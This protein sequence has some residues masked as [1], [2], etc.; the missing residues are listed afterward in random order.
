MDHGVAFLLG[1]FG[2]LFVER[3]RGVGE[4]R[5]ALRLL[6]AEIDRNEEIIRT[7]RER[8][9]GRPLEM[10]GDSALLS[11]KANEWHGAMRSGALLE[12]LESY[13]SPL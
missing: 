10:I 9:G 7:V 6:R 1:I 11:L 3:L 13:Y 5:G 8:R 12:E 2:T 4:R